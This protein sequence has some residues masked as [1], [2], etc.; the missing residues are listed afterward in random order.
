M[1]ERRKFWGAELNEGVAPK[2]LATFYAAAF[3]TIM[4]AVAY[5]VVQPYLLTTFLKTPMREL[6]DASGKIGVA[7]ELV[8]LALVGVW[9]VMSDRIGRRPIYA[10]GFV[11]MAA[12][13]VF[14]A[15]ID[16][17]AGLVQG[18]A[19]FSIGV[20][21]TTAMLS[22]VLADYVVNEDRGKATAVM[23]IMNGLGASVAATGLAKLPDAFAK[24]QGGVRAGQTSIYITAAICVFAGVL[25]AIGLRGKGGEQ[26]HEERVPLT[27]MAAEGVRAA[28]EDMGVVLCYLSAFV[29]RADLAVAGTFFPLWLTR[30]YQE[31]ATT[32]A[33]TGAALNAILDEAAARG[34]KEGGW[35]IAIAGGG[36]LLFAPVIGI[37]CDRINRVNALIIGLAMNVIGYGLVFFVHDPTTLLMFIAAGLIGFGQVG[38]VISSQVLIQQQA[39]AKFRGSVVGM[40]GTF[41]AAGIMFSLFF[42]GRLFDA[43]RGAGPFVLL[44]LLNVLVIGFA[45]VVKSRVKAPENEA[46]GAAVL[47]H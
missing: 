11:V 22:T 45:F 16:S 13:F 39:P 23:G 19:L 21:A 44:A 43:W 12:G 6:G 30:H 2:H 32:G 46:V 40:F 27:R 33:S 26:A 34:I 36:G 20:A 47:A 9:G 35:L 14:S 4:L 18:R 15:H 37:L 25:M 31:T 29:S 1:S 7:A 3:L 17:F 5:S 41:G 38:G 8:L 42:G 24:T 10:I 28:R